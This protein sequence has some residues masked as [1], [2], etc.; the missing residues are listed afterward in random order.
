MVA[1]M[2]HHDPTAIHYIDPPTIPEGMTVETYRRVRAAA[3][4]RKVHGIRRIMAPALTR[5]AD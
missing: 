3:R 2:T 4:N 5:W 1:V